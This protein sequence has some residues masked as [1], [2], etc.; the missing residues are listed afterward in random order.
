MKIMGWKMNLNGLN[1]KNFNRAVMLAIPHTTNWD[2]PIA[3]AAFYLMQIPVRFT[4]KKEWMKFPYSLLA[5]PLGGIAIDRSPRKAGEERKS[6]TEAMIDL[7][8]Q[9]EELVVMVT[10]EGTRSYNENWKTGFYYVAL[11]AKVPIALGY[12]DYA[13]KEAG[14]GMV[15]M[16]TGN[17][18]EDMQKIMD[19][20]RDI[21]GK[22]PENFTTDIKY[23]KKRKV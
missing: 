22:Y 16:P 18:E 8:N 23:D 3:R 13:K 9:N 15:F 4:V 6:M 19:F 20:Y 1:P 5:K 21:K 14:V 10:P 17:I 7:F 11:G 2:L 12:L